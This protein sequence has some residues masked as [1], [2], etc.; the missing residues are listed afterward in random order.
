MD[1]QLV[2]A[3]RV[4][5]TPVRSPRPARVPTPRPERHTLNQDAL[6]EALDRRLQGESLRSIGRSYGLTGERIRQLLEKLDPNHSLKAQRARQRVRQ[7]QLEA[8]FEDRVVQSEAN[9][10]QCVICYGTIVGAPSRITCGG[11]CAKLWTLC[12][13]QLDEHSRER[14][15]RAGARWVVEHPSQVT[16]YQLRYA[17]RVLEGTSER[18]GRWVNS[19]EIRKGLAEVARLRGQD[20]PAG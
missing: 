18:R 8:A 10:R 16:K 12:R 1:D 15:R 7:A 19:D 5:T 13:Y 14:A 4:L 20:L 6:Q 17:Q 3:S 9:G 11:R 2:A